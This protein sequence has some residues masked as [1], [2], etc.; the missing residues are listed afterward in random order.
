MINFKIISITIAINIL[1]KIYVFGQDTAI[2][3]LAPSIH[4]IY[5]GL[6]PLILY[7]G[8]PLYSSDELSKVDPQLIDSI[9]VTKDTIFDCNGQATYF[10]LIV[11]KTKDSQN[12]VLK[13]LLK[14]TNDLILRHPLIDYELNGQIV[15]HDIELKKQLFTLRIDDIRIIEIVKSDTDTVNCQNGLIKIKT[16]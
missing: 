1:S 5:S 8:I 15:N 14:K 13:Q 4:T 2:V 10:G 9:T 16:K 7:D 12:L 11:V 6:N 3:K